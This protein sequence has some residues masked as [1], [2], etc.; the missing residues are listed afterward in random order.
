MNVLPAFGAVT[1]LTYLEMTTTFRRYPQHS[2]RQKLGVQSH[3]L[4]KLNRLIDCRKL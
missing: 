4:V 3:T 1:E 2:E